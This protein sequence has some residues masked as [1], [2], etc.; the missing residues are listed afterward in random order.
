[1]KIKQFM[2]NNWKAVVKIYEYEKTLYAGQESLIT[3]NLL[4]ICL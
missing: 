2:L 3:T 1:M 4:E